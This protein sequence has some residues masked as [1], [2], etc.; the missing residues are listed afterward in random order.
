MAICAYCG[1]ENEVELRKPRGFHRRTTTSQQRRAER[2][3]RYN[4]EAEAILLNTRAMPDLVAGE[5]ATITTPVRAQSVESDWAV[6]ALQALTSGCGA[7]LLSVLPTWI[8]KLP[9]YTPLLVLPTVAGGAWFVTSKAARGLLMLV[10]EFTGQDIDGDGKV[11]ATWETKSEVK[12][13]KTTTHDTHKLTNPKA[14]HRFCKAV[15]G[16]KNFSQSESKKHKVP[17][18]DCATVYE[19]WTARGWLEPQGGRKSPRV[20]AAA[21]AHI[22]NYATTPPQTE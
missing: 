20:R 9:W 6:P 14:W 16:G 11:G 7:M 3:T 19:S 18:S 13:G 12:A 21:M 17:Q 8:A 10:E 5:K 15:V 22:R 1:K 4:S 2:A